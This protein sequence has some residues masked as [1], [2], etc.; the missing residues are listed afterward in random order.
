M[1]MSKF[2]SFSITGGD[3][4]MLSE[5]EKALIER[6][7]TRRLQEGMRY[8]AEHPEL[9]PFIMEDWV[10]FLPPE[11]VSNLPIASE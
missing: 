4:R 6:I 3:L 1:K 7:Q 5:R 11:N 9:G 10:E 8:Y 2:L